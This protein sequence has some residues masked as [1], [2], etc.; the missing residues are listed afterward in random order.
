MAF[1]ALRRDAAPGVDGLSWRDYEADLERNLDDLRERVQRGAYRALPSRRE[2]A[3]S[4]LL[5]M[6]RPGLASRRVPAVDE[7]Q[8][9]FIVLANPRCIAFDIWT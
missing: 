1:F 8:Q 6:A 5:M 2:P 4:I 9:W 7:T 3:G